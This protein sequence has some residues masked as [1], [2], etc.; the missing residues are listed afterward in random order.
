MSSSMSATSAWNVIVDAL[1]KNYMVGVDTSGSPNSYGLAPG[2]A[3][4]I[5]SA[6]ILRN[7]L[8][9]V[10]AR[11]YR[12]RNPWGSDSYTGPWS[13]NDSRWTAAYRS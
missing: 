2:H 5:V 8:G 10:V 13:D 1:N 11:L 9:G 12:I 4:T 3:H 6:H 7:S